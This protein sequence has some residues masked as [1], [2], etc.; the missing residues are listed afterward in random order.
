MSSWR[1]F[2]SVE[3]ELELEKKI[4][5]YD[6]I[7]KP[8]AKKDWVDRGCREKEMVLMPRVLQ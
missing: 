3:R 6:V 4:T 7:L 2:L 5:V 8:K 1:V